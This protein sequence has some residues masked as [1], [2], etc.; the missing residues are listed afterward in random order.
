MSA[1]AG[2]PQGGADMNMEPRQRRTA[3]IPSRAEGP[4]RKPK[5]YDL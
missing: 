2:P 1:V 5:T 3:I 4:G